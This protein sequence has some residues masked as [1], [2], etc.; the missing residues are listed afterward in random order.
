[1]SGKGR[2]YK[3]L[4]QSEANLTKQQQEAKY[5]AEILASDGYKLL[6]ISPPSYLSNTAKTEWKRIAPDLNKLPVRALD[7]AMV[8]NYCTWYAMF[9]DTTKLITSESDPLNRLD[10]VN[11]LDKITKNLKTCASELGL[12][13]DSRMRLN[14]P[15]DDKDK[16]KSLAD[17]IS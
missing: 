17:L 14:I 12:T 16:P 7:R 1:M 13:V 2:K 3:L 9:K 11:T 6:Q 5:N 8:E 15:K 10:Y 4:E